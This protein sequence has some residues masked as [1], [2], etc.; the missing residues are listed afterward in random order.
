MRVPLACA[1]IPGRPD[2]EVS[3]RCEGCYCVLS[4]QHVRRSVCLACMRRTG[5]CH[6]FSL[7]LA[8]QRSAWGSTFCTRT[9]SCT[10]T[11]KLQTSLLARRTAS[12]CGIASLRPNTAFRPFLPRSAC[13]IVFT[14][15]INEKFGRASCILQLGDLGIAKLAKTEGMAAKTQIGTAVGNMVVLP[16][17]LLRFL[18]RCH[19]QIPFATN[20]YVTDQRRTLQARRTTCRRRSGTTGHT[21]PPPTCGRSAVCCTSS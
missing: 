1:D 11:S 21:V 9:R 17:A 8:A 14:A 7:P 2:L 19:H 3:D 6:N 4:R 18:T 16:K 10:G 20:P 5:P 12:R 13:G 15:P